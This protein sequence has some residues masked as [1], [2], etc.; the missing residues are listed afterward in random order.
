[1]WDIKWKATSEQTRETNRN[2]LIDTDIM[3]FTRGKAGREL[4]K[5]KGGQINGE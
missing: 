3:V 2:K 4:R 1:M 5:G